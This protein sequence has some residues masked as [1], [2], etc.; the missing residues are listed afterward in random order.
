M[1][2]GFV[3]GIVLVLLKV[4]HQIDWPW[5]LVLLPLI[6]DFI[7]GVMAFILGIRLFGSHFRATEDMKRRNRSRDW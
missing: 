3:I 5:L 7:F 2:I 6:I 1:G 4:T